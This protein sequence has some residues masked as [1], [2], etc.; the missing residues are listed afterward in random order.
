MHRS[1]AALSGLAISA[2]PQQ[3]ML[4]FSFNLA[5]ACEVAHPNFV[6]NPVQ[7][8]DS[9]FWNFCTNFG[10]GL[11]SV[12]ASGCLFTVCVWSASPE[13]EKCYN[14]TQLAVE[15]NEMER[16]VA[17]TDS[18]LRPDQRL[19]EDGKMA[20]SDRVKLLLEQKQRA[21]RA[22]REKAAETLGISE[23]CIEM[24]N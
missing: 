21:V 12:I 6:G 18:R 16:G 11:R 3:A 4:G 9:G 22:E 15:L 24:L 10:R 19:L 20:E 5:E 14:F 13:L 17:P 1:A 7:G 2:L 23:F 8:L